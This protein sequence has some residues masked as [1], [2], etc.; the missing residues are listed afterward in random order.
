MNARERPGAVDRRVHARIAVAILI[1]GLTLTLGSACV[2]GS[3]VEPLPAPTTAEDVPRLTSF[4]AGVFGP[5]VVAQD[6]I[7]T[8]TRDRRDSLRLIRVDPKTGK[9]SRGGTLD[10]PYIG[11]VI[12]RGDEVWTVSYD[13][14]DQGGP[15]AGAIQRWERETLKP[16]DN[17]VFPGNVPM[18]IASSRDSIWVANSLGEGPGELW[19]VDPRTGQIVQRTK[20]GADLSN[21]LATNATI[22]VAD[23]L[24]PLLKVDPESGRVLD[25]IAVGSC[26]QDMIVHDGSLWVVTCA[27][28]VEVD[29]ASDEVDQEVHIR[30]AVTDVVFASGR[31]WVLHLGKD[32]LIGVDPET[33]EVTGAQIPVPDADSPP[34][35]L[36][37]G[38]GYVWVTSVDGVLTRINP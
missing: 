19:R 14:D 16:V 2:G 20:M 4:D 15:W 9:V 21:V 30:G 24:G 12:T 25:E 18:A 6:G 3:K 32:V 28:L 37:A 22:W 13:W 10:Q 33:G 36:A 23:A 26:S 8:T 5:M 34:S 29:L 38:G 27:G 17:S 35:D 1:V 11:G 7:W 31:L